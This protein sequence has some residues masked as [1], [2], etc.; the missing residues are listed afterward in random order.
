MSKISFS[1]EN[2]LK[3]RLGDEFFKALPKDAGVYTFV[4]SRGRP[5]YIGKADNL[6]RRLM[7]YRAA[8]P[9]L[10]ADH[11]LEMIEH[12]VNVKFEIHDDG[13]SALRRESELIR[14]VKPPYNV[15][16]K[17]DVSYL[18]LG[19]RSHERPGERG[20]SDV[21]FRLSHIDIK[22]AF[23]SFGCFRHRGK[24]KAGYS[25]LL[26]LFFAA[27]CPRERFLLPAKICRTS[28]PY[29]YTT[30]L[31]NEV[32]EPLES[33]LAGRD[34]ELLPLLFARLMERPNL[35][36]QLY[37]PLQRDI[38]AVKEFFAFGPQ[39]TRRLASRAKSRTGRIDQ[40]T[41]DRLI[42][43]DFQKSLAP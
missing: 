26:R 39:D 16:L 15:A 22:E 7:S 40:V 14:A 5:L 31:P 25:A 6:R 9:G 24:V 12:A 43:H 19:F 29:Q 27:Y 3:S 4:D 10:A 30:K 1:F 21:E 20:W 38:V 28:P 23:E 32:L 2:P 41:M 36:K 42:I 11:I 34:L 18:Y 33:F 13:S 37:I 35:P 17:W 8:K